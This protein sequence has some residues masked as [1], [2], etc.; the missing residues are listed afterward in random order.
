MEPESKRGTNDEDKKDLNK[1]KRSEDDNGEAG[2]KKTKKELLN[3]VDTDLDALN[4]SNIKCTT[5]GKSSN[6]KIASWN[7]A[8]IRAWLKVI[9]VPPNQYSVDSFILYL[10]RILFPR[11][12]ELTI[13]RKNK[14]T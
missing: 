11:K 9:W 10:L 8:G 1:R 2:N 3:K 4:V 7:V 5:D 13:L 6:F 12:M 14:L